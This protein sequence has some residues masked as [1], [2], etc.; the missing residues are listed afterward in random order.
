MVKID[1]RYHRPNEINTLRG[2][3]KKA[4]RNLGWKPKKNFKELVKEMVEND[5]KSIE[6]GNI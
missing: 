2:D 4:K 6:K 1:P 3:S 5:I